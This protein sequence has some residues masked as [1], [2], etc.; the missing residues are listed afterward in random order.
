MVVVALALL[1]AASQKELP[2]DSIQIIERIRHL[3]GHHYTWKEAI[4][5]TGPPYAGFP[6]WWVPAPGR[7]GVLSASCL[8]RI[9]G[10]IFFERR[11]P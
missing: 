1:A 10:I 3:A 7:A 9:A 6:E 4:R 11:P 2:G 8:G 5:Q